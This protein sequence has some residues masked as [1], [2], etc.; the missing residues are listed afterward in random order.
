VSFIGAGTCTIDANQGGDADYAPAPQVQQ[1][2]AVADAGGMTQQTIQFTSM[3]P[4]NAVVGGPSYLATA[5]ASSQLTV[6][7]T[8]DDASATVCAINNGTVTFVGAG[9]CA[10]NA[11]QGGDAIY[12]PAPQIQ[13]TFVVA[14]AGGGIPQTIQFTSTA[15]TDA[16]VNGPIYCASATA[17]SQLPVVLTIDGTSAT[18][19]TI[20]ND[21]VTF[22]AAG[23][24]TINANQGGDADYDPATQVQQGFPVLPLGEII[25]HSGFDNPLPPCQ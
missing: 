23:T 6:V 8:I 22:I 4:I 5:T 16:V 15:P 1:T 7:L 10:I 11:N 21:T 17:T 13:Q 25:M 18:V 19:C 24:C 14:D 12:A 3:A 20:N 9:A 2:F